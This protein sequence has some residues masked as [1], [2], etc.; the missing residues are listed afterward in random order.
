[1]TVLCPSERFYE[2]Q[3]RRHQTLAERAWQIIRVVVRWLPRRDLVFVADSSDA[4]LEWLH[5]V[6]EW[7]RARLITRLRLDAALDDPPPIREPGQLGRPRLTGDQRPTLEA[8]LA[9]EE[10][11]WSQL[12]I[13]RW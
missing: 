4:V 11:M 10:T 9:D 7:P 5:Q 2:P 8:V 3:G 6:S 13:E 1:M 12:T